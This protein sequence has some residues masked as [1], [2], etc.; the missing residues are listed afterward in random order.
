VIATA[1]V[2]H[3]LGT[4]FKESL[5]MVWMTWWPLVLG[6]VLAGVVQGMLPRATL[7][8]ELGSDSA[9]SHAKASLLGML[10]SSCSYAASA[11]AR[12]LFARGAS[13]TNS[14]VF[15]VASTNLVIE[16]G[17]VLFVLL[18]WPFVLAQLI[19]GIVMVVLL[20][21]ATPLMFRRA[22]VEGLA[23]RL[24]DDTTTSD[25]SSP[26]SRRERVGLSARYTM[27]DLTMVRKELVIGF[28]IAGFLS[29][30]VPPSW[31]SHIFINGHG[32]W[33]VLENVV[34]A[35]LV[36]VVA[37]VCSVGNVPLAAALWGHGVAFG[38]VVAF[39]FADL[40]TMPLL[41]IYRRYYGTDNAWRLFALLWATASGA[42]FI[43]DGL[44]HLSH[45]VPSSHRVRVLS[46]Q[47][48]L[49]ATLVL[50]VLA[51]IVLV[52]VWRLAHGARMDHHGATDPVC[53]MT[54]DPASAPASAVREGETY[55]FCSLGCRDKFTT[56]G[57]LETDIGGD[58][59]DPVCAMHVATSNITSVGPDGVTYYF[60][61]EGCR[62]TF[63][64]GSSPASHTASE[65]EHS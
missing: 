34:L 44:F 63:L 32:V 43:V 21:I 57:S 20:I 64:H 29:V 33:T 53:G 65:D 58:H 59:I 17:V 40:V 6:F 24:A 54:V 22:R 42:G 8:R 15:M 26:T 39:I 35:P 46:G 61:S 16:L 49:G 1:N 31:W 47:F 18:G 5:A 56:E 37:F 52:V 55:Y 10:S 62:S 60:C 9:G 30:H 19:G 3:W 38:G 2:L 7:R 12:A 11:M 51:L 45:L 28:V 48:P 4:G 36:A 50:N 23:Q 25:T 41:I 14:I 13:W 27:G